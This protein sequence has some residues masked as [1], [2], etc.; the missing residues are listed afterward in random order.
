VIGETGRRIP[1]RAEQ[2]E[3]KLAKK[4]G[5]PEQKKGKGN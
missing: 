4:A 2:G 5:N 1:H 3:W